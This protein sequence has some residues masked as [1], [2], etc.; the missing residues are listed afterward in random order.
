M[1]VYFFEMLAAVDFRMWVYTNKQGHGGLSIAVGG[2][3]MLRVKG[4]NETV[5]S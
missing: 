5:D 4:V 3:E 1:E 2:S